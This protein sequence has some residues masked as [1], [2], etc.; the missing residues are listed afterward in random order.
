MRFTR[1]GVS[2]VIPYAPQAA[3][4]SAMHSVKTPKINTPL[5]LFI[6]KIYKKQCSLM[7]LVG[8]KWY[9]GLN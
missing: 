1:A 9:T 3:D 7:N 8:K 2:T 5:K 4:L 6:F